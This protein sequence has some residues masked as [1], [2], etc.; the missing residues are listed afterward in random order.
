MSR[1]AI[2]SDFYSDLWYLK[3]AATQ[4]ALEAPRLASYAFNL[5]GKRDRLRHA[6]HD[7]R[8]S[9]C[10]RPHR[11]TTR[12][13]GSPEAG[14]VLLLMTAVNVAGCD[15]QGKP[16]HTHSLHAHL[17]PLCPRSLVRRPLHDKGLQL[18]HDR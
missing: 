14:F 16:H 4:M 6:Q 13:T 9:G 5:G 17:L 8:A 18:D 1:H 2:P 12:L 7:P 11:G 15:Q 10:G 3:S